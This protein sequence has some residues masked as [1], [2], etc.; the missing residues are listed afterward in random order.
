MSEKIKFFL[1]KRMLQIQLLTLYLLIMSFSLQAQMLFELEQQIAKTTQK[2]TNWVLLLIKAGDL[3]SDNSNFKKA[4]HYFQEALKYSQKL[5]YTNGIIKS[6]Y[7]AALAHRNE[8]NYK[9]SEEKHLK[10]IE[11]AQAQ[12]NE[13]QLMRS[14]L[15]LGNTYRNM[16]LHD[17]AIEYY[18]KSLELSQKL[19]NKRIEAASLNNIGEVFRFQSDERKAL[20]FYEKALKITREI[21]EERQMA[22]NLNNIGIIYFRLKEFSKA[23]EYL[24]ESLLLSEKLNNKK[25]LILNYTNLGNLVLQKEGKNNLQK[26]IEYHSKAIAIAE[27]LKDNYNLSIAKRNLARCYMLQKEYPKAL[28]LITEA[29][30]IAEKIDALNEKANGYYDLT[31]LKALTGADF[32]EI[33]EYETKYQKALNELQNDLLS[34]KIARLQNSYEYKQKEIENALLRKENKIKELQRAEA[35][36]LQKQKEQEN[37]ILTSQNNLLLMENKIKENALEKERLLREEAR[38]NAEKALKEKQL[39][40][41]DT[42]LQKTL[43][44]KQKYFVWG[45]SIIAILIA[46]LAFGLARAYQNRKQFAETL[47]IKNK[48]IEQQKEEILTQRNLL[49][50]Q[51]KLLTNQKEEILASIRYAKN[52]QTA[53]L[54]HE[55]RL[56][57]YFKDFWVL[58]RPKDIVSGDFYYFIE[59]NGKG[60]LAL[61]DCTGHGVPGAF[62]SALGIATLENTIV[63]KGI[64]RADEILKEMDFA[65]YKALNQNRSSEQT[66]GM[67]IALCV[68]DK[69]QKKI[70]CASANRPIWLFIDNTVIREIPPCYKKTLGTFHENTFTEPASIHFFQKS[71]KIYIFSDGYY[72]QFGGKNQKRLGKKNFYNLLNQTIQKPFKEQLPFIQQYFEKWKGAN[73]QI[74]DVSV[75]GAWVEC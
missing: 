44:E 10:A 39:L 73:E 9:L 43:L 38:A 1:P 47:Q 49:E 19:N 52:I 34:E 20:E 60:F 12:K 32:Q 72:D 71:C 58:Y 2:D 67:E 48:E 65:I 28:Q 24:K 62:M 37:I 53:L 35:Q 7:F 21:K 66:D 33:T 40:E 8:G 57:A 51:N 18:F 50:E 26:A 45:V 27:E 68:I 22:A 23:E 69:Q 46:S 64:Q 17:K 61:A 5:N 13:D 55:N 42:L 16:G 41:K 11:L 3:H 15:N 25:L 63:A 30:Q 70:E 75:I 56:Q 59:Y 4:H 14:Y 36:M 6:Y 31:L 29:L 74:D 54:P